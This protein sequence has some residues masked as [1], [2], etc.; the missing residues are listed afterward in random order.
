[1]KKVMLCSA[2]LGLVAATGTGP[3]R[4]D[5]GP[6]EVRV[7]AV[8]MD[9]ANGSDAIPALAVPKDAIHINSKVLPDVDFEYRFTPRWSAEL[10]LTYPQTQ[11]VTVERSALGGPVGIGSFKHLPPILTAKYNFLPDSDFQPY[12]GLG[13]NITLMYDDNIVVPVTGVGR[14]SIHSWSV[15]PAVQAGFDYRI[16]P[17]W[18]ANA[19]LKW[20]L[21]GTP[22]EVNDSV[23]VSYAHVNPL[24]FGVG[25]GYRF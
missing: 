19:D 16:A 18:Y 2:V 12:V 14:L 8:Y 1:M 17:H 7:R 25:L 11:Q 6:W 5:D 4:A 3:A 24:L 15:G 9:P 20:A 21:L 13:I 10:I 23:Q 22:L